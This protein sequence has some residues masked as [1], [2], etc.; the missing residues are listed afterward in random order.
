MIRH[1]FTWLL[2]VLI[3]DTLSALTLIAVADARGHTRMFAV[4]AV[5]GFIGLVAGLLLMI[6]LPGQPKPPAAPVQPS[7]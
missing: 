7:N 2:F 3:I 4:W 6:A 5:L 1:P